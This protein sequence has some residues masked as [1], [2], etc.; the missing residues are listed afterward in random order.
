MP[1]EHAVSIVEWPV[2]GRGSTHGLDGTFEG[3]FVVLIVIPLLLPVVVAV[4]AD[5]RFAVHLVLLERLVVSS[6]A[7]FAD[8]VGLDHR[9]SRTLLDRVV[10][11]RDGGQTISCDADELE[12]AQDEVSLDGA[13]PDLV[14]G[15]TDVLVVDLGLDRFFR[16]TT[17][18]LYR[19][20]R[21]VHA[22]K[23]ERDRS[24]LTKRF[25]VEECQHEIELVRTVCHFELG[26]HPAPPKERRLRWCSRRTP[27]SRHPSEPPA[28]IWPGIQT[29]ISQKMTPVKSRASKI[30]LF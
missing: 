25:G 21:S 17:L 14:V 29:I 18:T 1:D 6:V 28:T 5:G 16:G 9:G 8:P 23:R 19:G 4:G 11:D 27:L 7:L 10:G 30:T 3:I 20:G 2:L 22:L 15:R 26:C 13:Q 12:I 24:G